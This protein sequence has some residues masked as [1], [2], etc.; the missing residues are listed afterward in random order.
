MAA[1][2]P[3]VHGL[4]ARKAA[5]GARPPSSPPTSEYAVYRAHAPRPV[6]LTELVRV[7]GV[8]WKIEECFAGGKELTALDEH[9]VRSWTSWRRWTVLAMLAHAFLSVMTATQ[10]TPPTTTQPTPTQ[11]RSVDPR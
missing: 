3:A 8:R 2:I 10:P 11:P 6:P 9:Q 7:T 4:S 5:S 1:P